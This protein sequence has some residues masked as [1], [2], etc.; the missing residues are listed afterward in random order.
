MRFDAN[1]FCRK[2]FVYTKISCR[3]YK[4]RNILIYKLSKSTGYGILHKRINLSYDKLKYIFWLCVFG[5]RTRASS[6]G[7]CLRKLFPKIDLRLPKVALR[8][9]FVELKERGKT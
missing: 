8:V 9:F 4:H 2:C 3:D 5:I 1:I 6:K 7:R